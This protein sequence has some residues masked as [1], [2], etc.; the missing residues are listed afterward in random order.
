MGCGFLETVYQEC[1][2]REFHGQ[3][4]PYVAQQHLTLHYKGETL[5]QTYSPDFVCYE[6][7]VVE[8]KAVKELAPEH[9]AQLHNYLKAGKLELGLL[10]NFGHYPQVE[11]VSIV[12]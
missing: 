2:A 1:L 5:D 4:I 6:H 12:R 10:V 7:I 11:I 9:H 8:I 3:G